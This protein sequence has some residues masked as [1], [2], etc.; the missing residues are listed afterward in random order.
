[1]AIS[2]M[3]SETLLA[4]V[5]GFARR[6]GALILMVGVADT[7]AYGRAQDGFLVLAEF[8]V[9]M[10]LLY[11]VWGYGGRIAWAMLLILV[12][13]AMALIAEVVSAP[14]AGAGAAGFLVTQ[15]FAVLVSLFGLLSPAVRSRLQPIR[16]FQPKSFGRRG[17]SL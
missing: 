7:V 1:M 13:I 3:T 17:K 12:G 16:L 11:R 6:P 9:Q 10:F 14:Q 2:G 4:S 8:L 5:R 15:T